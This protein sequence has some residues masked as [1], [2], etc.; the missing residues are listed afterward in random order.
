VTRLRRVLITGASGFIGR[1]A[2]PLLRSR[3]FEVHAIGRDQADLLTPGIPA[4]LVNQIKPTHLLHLAWNATPGRF[5]TAPDNLDWVA[6]SL[7]L[8][9]AFAAAGGERAVFAGTCAEYDWSHGVLDE[10]ATLCNPSTVYGVAKDSLRRLLQA[11]PESVRL[12]WGRVFF[13]YGPH[14]APT[15]LV[16]DVITSLLAGREI[17]CSDGLVERDFMHVADV[18]AA[19]IA[20]LESDV[21]GPINI[22]SGLCLPLREVIGRIA[23][24]IGRPELVRLGARQNSVSEPPRLAA[25]IHRLRDEVGFRPERSLDEGL[26]ETIAWWRARS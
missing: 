22:A 17:L 25:V 7:A 10:A 5:W 23:E 19:L 18:A 16:P 4:A 11:S 21:A 14:E 12:S 15:R 3:G 13:L 9:R 20:V 24:E 26:M 8:H 2:V 1:H 6:A